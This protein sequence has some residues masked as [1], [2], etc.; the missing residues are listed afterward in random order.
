MKPMLFF[1]ILGLLAGTFLF[2]RIQPLSATVRI[3]GTTFIV[4]L[5]ITGKEIEKGLSGRS[6]L[7]PQHGMLF[8]FNHKEQYPFW[9][10]DMKFP[11]DFIW[12]DGNLIVDITKNVEPMEYGVIPRIKPIVPVDKIL[13]L[14]AG[15]IDAAGIQIGDTAL[16]NK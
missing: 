4:E 9:M 10:K 3:N 13:E 12:M 2:Y 15:E 7:A 6:S 5:A 1:I 8:L 14:T 16:F 11:L